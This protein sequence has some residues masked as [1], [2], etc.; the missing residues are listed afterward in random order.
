MPVDPRYLAEIEGKNGCCLI[1]APGTQTGLSKP[2]Q[3]L[4]WHDRDWICAPLVGDTPLGYAALAGPHNKLRPTRDLLHVIDIMVGQA[5]V[6]LQSQELCASIERAMDKRLAELA[7][8]LEIGSQINTRLNI[9]HVTQTALDWAIHTTCAL[10]G[11]I[12]LLEETSA[13]AAPNIEQNTW[14]AGHDLHRFVRCSVPEQHALRVIAHRGFSDER[15]V[16]RH[17]PW[18]THGELAGQVVQTGETVVIDETACNRKD[19]DQ[20]ISPHSHLTIPIKRDNAIVGMIRLESAVPRG[21]TAD[22]VAL[23]KRAADQVA[24]AIKN[25]QLYDQ[26]TRRITELESLHEI[27]LEMASS[28]HLGVVLDSLVA[29]AQSLIDAD[30][31]ELYLYDECQTRVT[32]QTGF[33]RQRPRELGSSPQGQEQIVQEVANTGQTQIVYTATNA[34]GPDSADQKICLT[35]SVP[36][37]K[38]GCVLGVLS[39][40]FQAPHSLVPDRLRVLHLLA[41]QAAVPIENAQLYAETRRAIKSKDKSINSASHEFKVPITS[42]HGYTRLITLQESGPITERQKTYLDIIQK[43]VAQINTLVDDLI[44]LSSTEP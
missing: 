5:A 38:S 31:I 32:Y 43:N 41:D 37:A 33:S 13:V 39:V 2:G 26:T 40:A 36:V 17:L 20:R 25:A 4:K 9:E 11:T 44:E 21:F 34:S 3:P 24:I 29:H 23:L 28:L 16:D 27:S 1:P 30:H 22:H 35:A 42:I 15:T 6:A 19:L 18:P 14:A 8:L 10:S 12:S 7:A